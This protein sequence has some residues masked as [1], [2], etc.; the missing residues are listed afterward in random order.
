MFRNVVLD[1]D[2]QRPVCGIGVH[3]CLIPCHFRLRDSIRPQGDPTAQ[4]V[5]AVFIAYGEAN[6]ITAILGKGMPER[7]FAVPRLAIAKAPAP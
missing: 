5:T 4:G 2:Q 7:P 6:L 3:R 1:A